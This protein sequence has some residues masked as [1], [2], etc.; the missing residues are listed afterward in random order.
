MEQ[1]QERAD[2]PEALVLLH[3]PGDANRRGG[4]PHGRP[5]RRMLRPP[6]QAVLEVPQMPA[7]GHRRNRREVTLQLRWTEGQVVGR[8]PGGPCAAYDSGAQPFV[9]EP[10]P[11]DDLLRVRAN[12]VRGDQPI[13]DLAWLRRETGGK[14]CNLTG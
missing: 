14:T 9:R 1:G 13:S 7:I 6:A 8:R 4:G 12:R 2:D 11:A 5:G 10:P 3:L